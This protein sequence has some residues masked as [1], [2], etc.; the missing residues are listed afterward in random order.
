MKNVRGKNDIKKIVYKIFA[1]G[2]LGTGLSILG[3]FTSTQLFIAL[4]FFSL[5]LVLWIIIAYGMMSLY[6]KEINKRTS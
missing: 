2:I 6:I 4:I 1:L 3:I 5:C